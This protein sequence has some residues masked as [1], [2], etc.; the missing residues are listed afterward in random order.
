[1]REAVPVPKVKARQVLE[2][3]EQ[4]NVDPGVVEKVEGNSFRTRV[5]PVAV[6]GVRK[7]V[8]GY[9][10]EVGREGNDYVYKILSDYSKEIEDYSV[11]LNIIS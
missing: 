1:M 8:I 2:A 10:E 3:L 11:T 7:I 9:D 6:G 5:Y 4:R